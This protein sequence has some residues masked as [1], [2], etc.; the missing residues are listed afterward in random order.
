MGKLQ[1]AFDS[2]LWNA[3][4]IQMIASHFD[5]Y[6]MLLLAADSWCHMLSWGLTL[7]M[8]ITSSGVL[9]QNG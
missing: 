3:V 4:S 5:G 8:P 6:M 1:M 7:T 2:W 9:I